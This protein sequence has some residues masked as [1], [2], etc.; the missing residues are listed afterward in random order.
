MTDKK[1]IINEILQLNEKFYKT[2]KTA[3]ESLV[4]GESASDHTDELF[5]IL[6]TIK[7]LSAMAEMKTLS[8]TMHKAEQLLND[9]RKGVVNADQNVID[10]LHK[11][12]TLV[13][14]A[15][16]Q[17][18][19]EKKDLKQIEREAKKITSENKTTETKTADYLQ[20]IPKEIR[21]YFTEIE[22]NKIA[23]NVKKGN[24]IILCKTSFDFEDFENKIEEIRKNLKNGEI[25]ALIPGDFY[26]D[27][28]KID[29]TLL[30]ATEKDVKKIK[31]IFP[32]NSKFKQL[33]NIEKKQ[34]K[35][36]EKNYAIPPILKIDWQ[37]VNTL[38]GDIDDIESA[39]N[40]LLKK[41]KELM[42]ERDFEKLEF[43]IS[44]LNKK[45]STLHK[46][47]VNLRLISLWPLFQL[48][49]NTIRTTAETLNK[50]VKISIKGAN[51]KIDKPIVDSLIEPLLHLARNAVDHG[52]ET[53]QE[54]IKKGKPEYGT[55][56]IEAYQ[57]ENSVF[58]EFS[59]DGK[60]IDFQTI[61]E[62]AKDLNILK[63]FNTITNEQ[64]L[65]LLFLPGFSTKNKA[66]QISGRGIG[67]DSVKNT[68]TSIGGDIFVKTEK[69]KGTKFILKLPL[70]T[71]IMPLFFVEVENFVIAIPEVSITKIENFDKNKMAYL[72]NKTYYKCE[73]EPVPLINLPQL[74]NKITVFSPLA[75][76]I[77]VN[78]ANTTVC[79]LIDRIIDHSEKP[80]IPFKGK[81]KNLPLFSSVC[82]FRENKVAYVLNLSQLIEFTRNKYESNIKIR[83]L[84]F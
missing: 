65:Q 80:I 36:K 26:Q 78:F 16:E 77:T 20:I 60:G 76:V 56:K 54:R 79:V 47:I 57:S 74:L 45:L 12:R 53:P 5:R 58:I 84:G 13:N 37:K 23:L 10:L 68:L 3:E 25:I 21:E 42:P 51:T 66:S 44:M 17:N 18:D 19:I 39:K 49:E 75:N 62:K 73:N 35:E 40:A 61:R 48:I 72:H 11:C 6:H 34:K 41:A 22:L 64:L 28:N 70:T 63:S 46:N 69:G 15:V 38:L 8:K 30:I 27:G 29:F 32:E 67:L 14:K 81:L 71:A 55:I 83:T 50:K 59:D 2:L 52:I 1:G 43:N 82:R 4:K 9:I 33:E 24:K 7:G 31:K